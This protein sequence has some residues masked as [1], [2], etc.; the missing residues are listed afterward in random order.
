[1]VEKEDPKAKIAR[2]ASATSPLTGYPVGLSECGCPNNILYQ[3]P[4]LHICPECGFDGKYEHVHIKC[5]GCE[6]LSEGGKGVW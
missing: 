3:E 2:L 6:F 1:M 4:I 5:Q